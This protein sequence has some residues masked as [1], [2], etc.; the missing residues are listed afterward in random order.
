MMQGTSNS[1]W[2]P[3][4][5][6]WHNLCCSLPHGSLLWS[7]VERSVVQGRV[8]SRWHVEFFGTALFGATEVPNQGCYPQMR[9]FLHIKWNNRVH[10]LFPLR[11]F[12]YILSP[13]QYIRDIL[14]S[15]NL[16]AVSPS[17][18]TKKRFMISTF[19]CLQWSFSSG[20]PLK[21]LWRFHWHSHNS[22]LDSPF[23]AS[24]SWQ[25]CPHD[26]HMGWSTDYIAPHHIAF[27]YS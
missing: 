14:G 17:E 2:Y 18:M 5:S 7:M 20:P 23:P 8:W 26:S 13:S 24:V 12:S 21:S 9:L 19:S 10:Q 22:L 25:W 11:F 16:I 1:L 3:D 4:V 6:L 15:W 27:L